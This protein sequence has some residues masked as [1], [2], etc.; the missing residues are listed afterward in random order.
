MEDIGHSGFTVL[1]TDQL[2]F[3]TSI[4]HCGMSEMLAV[5]MDVVFVLSVVHLQCRRC[6]ICVQAAAQEKAMSSLFDT[7]TDYCQLLSEYLAQLH[8]IKSNLV[9]GSDKM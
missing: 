3:P 6:C 8:G 7:D 9:V 1:N 5:C 4:Q 2:I